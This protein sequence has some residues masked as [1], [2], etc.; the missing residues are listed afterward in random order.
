[1][2]TTMRKYLDGEDRLVLWLSEAASWMNELE[3]IDFTE[4][5]LAEIERVWDAFTE[6][7]ERLSVRFGFNR[8]YV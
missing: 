1:M 4:D 2:M 6:M 3:P 8:F 5:E 7:Q